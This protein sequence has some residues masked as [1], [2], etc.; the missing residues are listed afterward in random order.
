MTIHFYIPP[1]SLP[2]YS[3]NTN[4]SS[5]VAH[6]APTWQDPS[7]DYDAGFSKAMDLTRTEFLDRV[8]YYGK[9]WWGARDTVAKVLQVQDMT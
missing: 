2:R 9:V 7:P 1:V 4:L 3:I 6:L 5:R 8:N